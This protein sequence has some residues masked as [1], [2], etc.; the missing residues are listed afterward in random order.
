MT[1]KLV[2]LPRS[3]K[4][5]IINDHTINFNIVKIPLSKTQKLPHTRQPIILSNINH[6]LIIDLPNYILLHQSQPT[7]SRPRHR[8]AQ[9][10]KGLPYPPCRLA[11]SAVVAE[12]VCSAYRHTHIYIFPPSTVTTTRNY[13]MV[14]DHMSSHVT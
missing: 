1:L 7:F 8:R 9:A 14:G 2:Y 12:E 3:I 10:A 13:Y 4:L 6:P 5:H 11:D